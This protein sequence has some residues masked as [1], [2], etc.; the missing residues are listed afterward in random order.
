MVPMHSKKRKGAFHEPPSRPRRRPR[1]R[2]SGLSSRTK[3]RTSRFM[4]PMHGLKAERALHEPTVRSHG[5]SRFGPPEGGTPNKWRPHGPVHG[6]NA[7]EKPNG[8]TAHLGPA[9]P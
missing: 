1:P 6:P 7:C 5:F 2:L 9:F 3:T 4:V 8:G